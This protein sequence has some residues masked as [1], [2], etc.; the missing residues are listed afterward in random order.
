MSH[1]Y[2]TPL[3]EGGV[4][5]SG[6]QRQRISIAQALL[7]QAPII[8]LDEPTSALDP[9]HE[10]QIVETLAALRGRR[11]IILVTHRAETTRDC[12]E[13]YEFKAGRSPGRIV[14]VRPAL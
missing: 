14:R 12:N 8:V 7:T 5:L 3:A 4:N 11:T 10:R 13:V 9:D 6:G 2:D 1:G